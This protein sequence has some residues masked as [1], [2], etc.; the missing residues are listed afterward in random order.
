MK[1]Y[2]EAIMFPL[3]K[4]PEAIADMLGIAAISAVT[5]AVLWLG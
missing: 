4:L 2:A 3:S 1:T 5:V